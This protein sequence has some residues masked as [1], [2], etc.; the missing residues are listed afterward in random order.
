MNQLEEITSTVFKKVIHKKVCLPS[1]YA[2]LFNAGLKEKDLEPESGEK[3]LILTEEIEAESKKL[4]ILS[5]KTEKIVHD[6]KE[7]IDKTQDIDDEDKYQSLQKEMSQMLEKI[8]FL[9]SEIYKDELTNLKNRKWLYHVFLQEQILKSAGTMIFLDLNKFKLINDTYGHNIGDKTLIYFSTFIT[10]QLKTIFDTEDFYFI[11]YAG[12]EFVLILNNSSS[13]DKSTIEQII[14]D[15]RK[16]LNT[17]K[18]AGKGKSKESFIIDFSYGI[19]FFSEGDSFDNIL[20]AAD[21]NMYK[22]KKAK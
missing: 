12:D 6:S 18:F 20:I 11:R 22:M 21:D 17:K 2:E 13:S 5:E 1:E 19:E 8:N 9:N 15:I 14:I 4:E 7:I 10:K 16:N 3:H